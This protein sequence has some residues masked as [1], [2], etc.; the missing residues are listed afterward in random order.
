MQLN[1]ERKIQNLLKPSDELLKFIK[2]KTTIPLNCQLWLSLLKHKFVKS[3][4]V[5]K[6]EKED[7]CGMNYVN[8]EALTTGLMIHTFGT[9]V[10][11]QVT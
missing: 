7:M 8:C 6:W 11:Q 9:I 5:Y 10:H 3:L 1:F 4:S 2:R